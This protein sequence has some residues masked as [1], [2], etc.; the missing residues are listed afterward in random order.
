M[1]RKEKLMR[2]CLLIITMTDEPPWGEWGDQKEW[3][4]VAFS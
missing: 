2:D 1:K 3:N 4:W